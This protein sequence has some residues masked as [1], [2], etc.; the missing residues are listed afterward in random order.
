M[1]NPKSILYVQIVGLWDVTCT[2]F[3]LSIIWHCF[4][5]YC[6]SCCCQSSVTC[7]VTGYAIT[8]CCPTKRWI[9]HS[10]LSHMKLKEWF[11]GV[12]L[13]VY[14]TSIVGF[15]LCG[16]L[17]VKCTFVEYQTPLTRLSIVG[18]LL[19]GIM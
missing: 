18:L 11:I 13:V 7:L 10:A 9:T 1:F 8:R 12:Q 5:I 6:L 2:N 14:R 4:V 3:R 15:L 17:N 19:C 16:L